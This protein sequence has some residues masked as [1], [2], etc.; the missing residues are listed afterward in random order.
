MKFSNEEGMYRVK[1]CV[2]E[3]FK[4]DETLYSCGEKQTQHTHVHASFSFVSSGHYLEKIGKTT[5][6]RSSSSVVFRPAYESHAV[7]F[8]SNVRILCVRLS[9]EK[10]AY[11]QER[12]SVFDSPSSCRTYEASWLGERLR[13]EL[14]RR[15]ASS[16]LAIEGLALE[17]LAE[18]ARVKIKREKRLP[19]WL[20]EAKDFLHDNFSVSFN[21]QDVAEISGVHSAHLSRVFREKYNCTIGE[22]VRRL[23]AE[24]ARQ[25]ILTTN[26]PLSEIAVT[27]GFSDQSHFNR[28]FK[29]F[30]NLTPREYRRV[31]R[32]R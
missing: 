12:L 30:F 28:I 17:M 4:V 16:A 8:E 14:R 25:Q 7:D 31:S 29:Q 2:T 22:Y 26:L 9:I 5:H 21:V 27:S 3:H 10:L 23:R 15:D 32:S 18:V 1:S 13:Q 19:P 6:S 24:Y 20:E 11:M